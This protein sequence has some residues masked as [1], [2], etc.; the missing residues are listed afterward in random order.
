MVDVGNYT[1]FESLA[2]KLTS[3]RSKVLV[4]VCVYRP[5]GTV[6]S[7]F[8][9][10]LSDMLDQIMLLGNRFVVVGDFNVP[11]DVAGQLDPRAVD[12]L[13]QYG[14]R[15]QVA[16]PTHITGNTL[17]LIL[18]RDEQISEQLV[19]KVTVQ[20]VCFSDHHLLTCCLGVPLPQLVAMTYN[21]RSLHRID[22][23]AFSADILQ[24][25][26]Y[27]ELELTIQPK[28]N[29]QT[30][31][32]KPLFTF[33]LWKKGGNGNFVSFLITDINSIIVLKHLLNKT[34]PIFSNLSCVCST[35]IIQYSTKS[36]RNVLYL[37]N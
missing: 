25:R 13:T 9:D 32:N 16:G 21:Y 29:V 11:G 26:L 20:S 31:R 6:T 5:L 18:S 10:Q 15:Q 36:Q 28:H 37:V 2:I 33:T 23:A 30:L 1:E 19:S 35:I 27:S 24:S 8:T 7:T 4:M 17:D 34:S 3:R 14:L 22:T 12:V